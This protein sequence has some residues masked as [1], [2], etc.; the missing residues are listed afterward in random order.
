MFDTII[1][2]VT[3]KTRSELREKIMIILYQI[4]INRKQNIDYSVE[5]IIRENLDIDNEFVRDIVYGVITYESDIIKEANKYMKDW[6]IER[7]D[8]TGAA[9]LKMAIYEL[10]YTDTPP[11]VVINE[12]IELAKKYSDDDVRKMINAVLDKM[13]KE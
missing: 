6:S 13:I 10:K 3:M 2:E 1:K 9:I 5:E 4:D 12:A 11:I 8:K 7:I